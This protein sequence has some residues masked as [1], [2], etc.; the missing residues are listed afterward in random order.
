MNP[1][2]TAGAA[3]LFSLVLALSACGGADRPEE[4]AGAAAEDGA[5][6]EATAADGFEI[7]D[8][9]IKA[10]TVD[11]GMTAVFGEITNGSDADVTIVSAAHE[12]AGMVELHE[13]V[14]DGAETT[15]REVEGGFPI[16]AGGSRVLE[17]G[18]DHIMLM[19]LNTD[20][21]PGTES[22][23]TVEFDDG[24]TAE[25]TAQV[26]EFAGA[27]EEYDGGGD[28]EEYEE[29]HGDHEGEHTEDEG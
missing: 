28:E 10:A 5:A 15:M 21:E 7:T 1:T 2:R 14:T 20:L 23:V 11:D 18:G 3:A 25:F 17:A 26:K 6:E 16:P 27:N 24:S 8:P 4:Q 29:G 22:T 12:A 13:G 19:D 9:W